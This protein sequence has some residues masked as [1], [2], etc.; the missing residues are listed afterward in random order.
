MAAHTSRPHRYWTQTSGETPRQNWYGAADH[1]VPIMQATLR[2]R[3]H[4]ME[5]KPLFITGRNHLEINTQAQIVFCFCA[6]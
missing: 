1:E 5:G 4:I 2:T 6:K 3:W